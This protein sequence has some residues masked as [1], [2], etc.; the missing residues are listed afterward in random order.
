MK[1]IYLTLEAKQ[2][3]EA[4]IAE[5]ENIHEPQRDFDY[6]RD[7]EIYKETL[8]SVTILP[9]E[10]SWNNVLVEVMATGNYNV[11]YPNGVIISK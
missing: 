10:K 6:S 7:I 3:I 4:K 11:S 8:S 9:V 1:G 5:L 2:E